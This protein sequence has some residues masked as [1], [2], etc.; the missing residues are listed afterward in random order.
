MIAAYVALGALGL[1]LLG[2]LFTYQALVRARNR[3]D[4]AW[5]VVETQ[6]EHRRD[7]VPRLVETV[8]GHVPHETETLQAVAEA[9]TAT[10]GARDPL[11]VEFAEATL[12][13]TLGRVKALGNAY[14]GLR[15]AER[16][17]RLQADL[18]AVDEGIQ[19]ARMA[20]NA[21]VERYERRTHRF[22]ALL[23]ARAL[24][25]GPRASFEVE[26]SAER[27]GESK[28]VKADSLHAA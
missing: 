11:A 14:P 6:L 12:T 9:H 25:F 27:S 23:I 4:R 1:L 15:A 18:T 7:L 20:Y 17:Q 26:S 10:V 22:P 21:Q 5:R 24:S 19:A 2:V 16:F 28:E 13:G 3:V 8:R